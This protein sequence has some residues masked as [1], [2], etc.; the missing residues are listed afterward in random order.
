MAED[1][2]L[3]SVPSI[4]NSIPVVFNGWSI[5]HIAFATALT[6]DTC[7]PSGEGGGG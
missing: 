4:T 7:W 3:L 5:P 6:K 1:L 2:R